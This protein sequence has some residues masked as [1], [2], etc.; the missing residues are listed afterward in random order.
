VRNIICMIF[1]S[2]PVDSLHAR[3][4][5]GGAVTVLIALLS[6]ESGKI[7]SLSIR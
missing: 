2:N 7:R 1:D 6:N 3:L 5:A 4:F